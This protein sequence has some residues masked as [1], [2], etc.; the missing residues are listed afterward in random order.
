LSEHEQES[1]LAETARDPEQGRESALT[2]ANATAG[3]SRL[4]AALLSF[5]WPGLG[6]LYSRRRLAAAF[7]AVPVVLAALWLAL[8]VANGVGYFGADFLDNSFALGFVIGVAVL[9]LWR[10]ASMIHAYAVAGPR[11]RPSRVDTVVIAILLIA[12]VAAHGFAANLA[13]AA[14]NFDNGVASNQLIPDQPTP[15]PAGMATAP[16]TASPSPTL[17]WRPP[18]TGSPE[19]TPSPSPTAAP[20]HRI[21]ILLTGVDFL[22]GRRHALNDSILIASLDTQTY[23]ASILSIPRD[24][25]NFDFYWGG[26]AGINTKINNFASLVASG[27]IRAPDPAATALAKEVGWLGGLKVDYYVIV[28]IA[29]FGQLVDA[30]HG[31][32]VNNP[33]AIDDPMTGTF[34][35]AGNQ[36]MDGAFVSPLSYR[37]NYLQCLDRITTSVEEIVVDPEVR[38]AETIEDL[39]RRIETVIFS[40]AALI[41]CWYIKNPPWLQINKDKNNRGEWMAGHPQVEEGVRKLLELRMSFVPYLYA[42]FNEYHLK[43]MPPIRAL[44]LDWPDD[45]AVREIDDQYMFG[46]SVMVAPMF[47]GQKTRSVYLPAGDWYDFWTHQR[48]AGGQKIEVACPPEQIPLFVKS[49]SLLPLAKP[50]EN[51]SSC[52]SVLASEFRAACS[53]VKCNP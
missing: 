47:L 11:R 10:A 17:A 23:K 45:P 38:D 8:Q 28:D 32:C 3:R 9:G 22:A 31:V 7:F 20:S 26:T 46:A 34:I 36:C 44:V 6:Q 37:R 14:Y 53:L 48:H 33:R 13:L 5:L 27:A 52:S 49:G 19:P 4:V 39:Y 12:V 2:P 30:A 18:S 1:E 41:N 35:P 40:P 16:P 43:G 25:A 15:T 29:G 24:T 50:L 42:A 21:T 51:I